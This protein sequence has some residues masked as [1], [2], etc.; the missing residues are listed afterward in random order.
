MSLADVRAVDVR[1]C[2]GSHGAGCD[3][4]GVGGLG[5]FLRL[6]EMHPT[7]APSLGSHPWSCLGRCMGGWQRLPRRERCCGANHRRE[8]ALWHRRRPRP[9]GPLTIEAVVSDDIGNARESGIGSMGRNQAGAACRYWMAILQERVA[10]PET[11]AAG[12]V[13]TP[14]R[15]CVPPASELASGRAVAGAAR[16]W[17]GANIRWCEAP[18]LQMSSQWACG[19]SGG[20]SQPQS[21]SGGR[22]R[23]GR[24]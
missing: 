21:G 11:A 19:G 24:V 18:P 4:R 14:G 16:L 17:Q 9:E 12:D 23:R 5:L 10:G 8:G 13:E 1:H 22:S 3:A 7:S 2:G 20:P 15:G 6:R